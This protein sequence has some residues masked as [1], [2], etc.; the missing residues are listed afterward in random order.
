[1]ITREKSPEDVAELK[2]ALATGTS[3]EVHA[4]AGKY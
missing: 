3:K 2:K 1:M 4:S